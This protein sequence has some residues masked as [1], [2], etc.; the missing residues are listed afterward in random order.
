LLVPGGNC[1]EVAVA[2]GPSATTLCTD[3]KDEELF[4]RGVLAS[5]V[6]KVT[7]TDPSSLSAALK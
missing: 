6:L 7:S 1:F 2:T 4:G 5:R 3:E